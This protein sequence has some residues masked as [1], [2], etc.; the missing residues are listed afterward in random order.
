M[1]SVNKFLNEADPSILCPSKLHYIVNLFFVGTVNELSSY[2]PR[3]KREIDFSKH[4]V[5]EAFSILTATIYQMFKT[6]RIEFEVLRRA[7]F[8]NANTLF[9]ASIPEELVVRIQGS[10]SLNKL[11]DVLASSPSYWSWINIRILTKMVGVSGITEAVELVERYKQAV[12]SRKLGMLLEQIPRIDIPTN[13]YSRVKQKWK[14]SL[15]EVTVQDLVTHWSNMEKLFD[16][17][18]PTLLLSKVVDGCVEIHWLIPTHLVDHVSSAVFNARRT[19]TS[20]ICL[21]I[22]GHVILCND[23]ETE[24]SSGNHT[25]CMYMFLYNFLFCDSQ[26]PALVVLPRETS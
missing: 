2:Q 19:V 21:K 23:E 12:F 5:D 11:F 26:I 24:E 3:E 9:G 25:V 20:I 7:C 6:H 10:D 22:N 4:N 1:L 8:E 14:R 13:Y 16:V 15:D 17:K 18:E